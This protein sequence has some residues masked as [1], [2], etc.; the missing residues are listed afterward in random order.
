MITLAEM[1][2]AV[3]SGLLMLTG[4]AFFVLSMFVIGGLGYWALR[5]ISRWLGFEDFYFK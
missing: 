1:F 2:C 3:Y 4:L 5:Y